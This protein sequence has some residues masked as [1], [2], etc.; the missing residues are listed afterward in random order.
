MVNPKSRFLLLV[1][2]F[3]ASLFFRL[4]DL[5]SVG[6]SEDESNKI[7]AAENYRQGTFVDNAEH[8]MLMKLLC[9][10]SLISAERLNDFFHTSITPEAALRFP[11][12]LAGSLTSVALYGLGVE[13]LNPA[14]AIIAAS[15]WAVDINGVALSRVAKE[16]P[17]V[18]LFFVLGSIFLLRAKRNH[19]EDPD[20][21]ARNYALCGAC[22][23][24]LFASKYL[25]PILWL[26]LIYYDIFRFRN[27]PRWR[28]PRGAWMKICAAF[29]LSFLIADPI[30]LSPNTWH[31]AWNHFNHRAM[32][33]TGYF[34]MNQIIGNKAIYTLW[35]VPPYFYLLYFFVKTPLVML[36]FLAIGLFYTLRS[37]REDRF[38]FLAMYFVLWLLLLSLP[39]GK[40]TR[41]AITLL[42][43]VI[44]LEALG[45]YIVYVAVRGH[46]EKRFAPQWIGHAVLVLLLLSSVGWYVFLNLQYSPHNSMYVAGQA[47]GKS[48]RGYFFPQDDIYDAGLREAIQQVCREAPLKSAVLGTTPAV[49]RYYQQRFGRPD[50]QFHSTADPTLILDPGLKPYILYQEY[51]SYLE[52]N[53]LNIFFRWALRPLHTIEIQG[54]TAVIV[55]RLCRENTC[56]R[57]PFW[58]SPRWP[59]RLSG[60]SKT[61]G[62]EG[63]L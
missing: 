14:A 18:T 20:R 23:G 17:L 42:P 29:L 3:T 26:P 56:A 40:F 12:A 2:L 8:P 48:R 13:L 19:F 16:D 55:Y 46:L 43:A 60:L 52:N 36:I 54:V 1:L 11:V 34:M 63:N 33:H 10:A 59:G 31:Y 51:R 9:T 50:L 30:V 57:V 45:I 22:F 32:T 28:I 4:W 44:L 41:Y 37:F 61:D 5:G 21:A 7:L 58:N 53:Y 47:G 6:L 24:L 62:K 49:F 38:L 39:G 27:E 15:L 35:G 25:L